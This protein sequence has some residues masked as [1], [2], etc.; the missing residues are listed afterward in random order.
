MKN[1]CY[2]IDN[3]EFMSEIPNKFYDLAIADPPY[4]IGEGSGEKNLTRGNKASPTKYHSYDDKPPDKEYFNELFRISKNQIIWGANHF[5]SKI[6][7][8]SS[9][10]IVW[11]KLNGNTDQADCELA[12][13][14]FDCSARI[15]KF[16]WQGMLQGNM[17]NKEH[18]I[19][20]NQK[21]VA[22]YKWSLRKFAKPGWK[23][24]DSHVGSGSIRVVCFDMDLYFEGCEIKPVFHEDQE[25][26]FKNH[27]SK[28]KESSGDLWNKEEIQEFVYQQAEFI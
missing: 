2:L 3:M 19:H 20:I 13:T 26:R 10:W 28:H 12:W 17:K 15:F 5:I 14:S 6:P 18:R 27:V 8:D 11:D 25:K 23:I 1:E 24:F 21:P 7:Y 4:G 16:R 22:L 9:C